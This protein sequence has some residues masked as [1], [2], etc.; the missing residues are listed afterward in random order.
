MTCCFFVA[1]LKRSI[2]RVLARSV[3]ALTSPSATAAFDYLIRRV[4]RSA[5]NSPKS[6]KDVRDIL[7]VRPD[8]I[9]DVILTGPLLRELRRAFPEARITVIVAPRALDVVQAC[10]HVDEVVTVHIPPPVSVVETWWRPLE[11]RL[12]AISVARRHLR[13]AEYDVALVPR[14]GVD[15]HEASVLAYLSGAPIRV[16]YSE[17]VSPERRD[18]NSGFDRYFTHVVD[19]RSI[20]HEVQRNLALLSELGI[21]ASDSRLEAW[22]TAK[23]CDFAN[24]VLPSRGSKPLV[25]LGLGAGHRKRLW[26]IARF[27]EVGQWLMNRGARLVIVGGPGDEVLASEF[28]ERTATSVIDLVGKGATLRQSVAALR[29]CSLFCGND[30]G[31]MHLA[32]AAGIPVVEISCHARDGDELHP[33]SPTRFGPWGVPHRILRPERLADG[34]VGGCRVHVPHCILGV[35]VESVIAAVDSLMEEA[36]T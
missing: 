15:L 14:W 3:R 17:H 9:G 6:G 29:K 19:D 18:R 34:C 16:G 25:A 27:V 26:P 12:A 1:D 10:P 30:G 31:P 7:V 20:K 32:A 4:R 13:G 11:R 22:L 36:G 21:S 8:G 35:N 5:R 28:R 33:N 23:D 2:A 24:E